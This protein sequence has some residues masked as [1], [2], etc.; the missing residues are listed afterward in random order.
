MA[1]GGYVGGFD[2]WIV[3]TEGT[4]TMNGALQAVAG[5]V[6]LHPH[7]GDA[8]TTS[9]L[10]AGVNWSP[11]RGRFGFDNR[12]LVE[13][14]STSNRIAPRVR[15]RLRLSWAIAED[16]SVR[17]FAAVE[18]FAID[19]RGLSERRYQAG[20]MLPV[21]HVSLETYWLRSVAR[22]RSPF[23]TLGVTMLWRVAAR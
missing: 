13:R 14:R 9:I 7:D 1:T 17:L 5:H 4:F 20:L 10:R 21:K 23:D 18:A 22:T 3:L 2:S 11:L 19:R 15:D 8:M 12:F 6:V 16:S